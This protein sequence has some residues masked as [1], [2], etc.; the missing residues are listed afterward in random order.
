MSELDL[1]EKWLNIML[2]SVID[3]SMAPTK[4]ARF[5][6]LVS[7]IMYY[8]F[9]TYK[10]VKISSLKEAELVFIYT[11]EKNILAID[12]VILQSMM[13]LYDQLGL[14]KNNL[15]APKSDLNEASKSVIQNIKLFLDRRNNDNHK[16]AGDV[17][18]NEHFKNSK[19]SIDTNNKNQDLSSL[20]PTTWTPL[21]Q[22]M[23]V[24]K[25]ATPFWGNVS[26]VENLSIDKYMKIADDNKNNQEKRDADIENLLTIYENMDDT[27]RMIGEFFQGGKTNPPGMWNI[28]GLYAIKT[29]KIN[30]VSAAEFLYL[31]NSIMFTGSIVA[32]NIKYKY[33]QARPIQVIRMMG[34]RIVTTFDGTKV[35]AKRWQPFQQ[36]GNLTPPFPDFV[37]G[38]SMFS[39]GASKVF[40]KFFPELFSKVNFVPFN[41]RHGSMLT[42]LLYNNAY[43]NTI[44]DIYINKDSSSIYSTDSHG[45]RIKYPR[46]G[47]SLKFTS[48]RD[49]AISCGISRL[50]GGIHDENAN[51]VSFMIG[52]VIAADILSR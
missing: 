38:H 17:I 45:G 29:T 15:V 7:T 33:I 4:T 30:S 31:L 42:P 3:A 51:K 46:N 8:S 6:Y 44:K 41:N 21:K 22:G 14:N 37:S 49:I 11:N 1:I 5:Q 16:K 25:Y 12:N 34:D 36:E 26:L 20:D 39:S 50:Y 43:V 32:W 40:D 10:N 27:Q 23:K 18:P 2:D 28:Y 47:V 35:P 9:V 48:W 13:Y 24:Q 52:D 19:L